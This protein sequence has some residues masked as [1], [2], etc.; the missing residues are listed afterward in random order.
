MKIERR[1]K[2]ALLLSMLV[3]CAMRTGAMNLKA[4]EDTLALH[5]RAIASASVDSIRIQHSE[6]MRHRF[7]SLFDEAATFQH[8]FTSL[9][10]C[11]LT[12]SDG[13]IRLFNWNVPLTDGTHKYVCFVLVWDEKEKNYWWTELTEPKREAEKIETKFLTEDKWLGA[14][15]YEVI[16]VAK[17]GS[18]TYTLLGWDG[19]D[20]LTQ[21]KIVDAIT[22]TGKK[23]RIGASI[24][25]TADGNRKRM[26]FEYSDEVSSSVRY[27][28]KKNCIVIDHLSPKSDAMVGIYADYGPDGSYDALTLVKGKWE[29]IENIDVSQFAE[30]NDK[31]FIDPRKGR[32]R[33]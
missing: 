9:R 21:R 13:R 6:M 2:T 32:R 4:E 12:S 18:D 27:H 29:I 14:L 30:G 33:K 10:F 20:K 24:F 11:T 31:P 26:L 28:A 1:M 5:Y 8:A 17:K 23:I 25:K 15:Y 7:I 19:K 22:I 16:P 3:C